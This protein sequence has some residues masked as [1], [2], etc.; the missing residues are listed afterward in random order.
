MQERFRLEQLRRRV[1]GNPA[2]IAFAE[3]AEAY[4]RSGML[5]EAIATCRAGLRRHP[6]YAPARVTLA[7]ALIE[8]GGLDE[9]ERELET[10]LRSAPENLAALHGLARVHAIRSGTPLPVASEP[11]PEDRQ[12]ALLGGWLT[13][14]SSVRTVARPG[15]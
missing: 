1:A 6:A 13:A 7:V 10:V 11:T 9:A 14:I 2:S 15:R 8:Q 3:L 5:D 4:R 12:L